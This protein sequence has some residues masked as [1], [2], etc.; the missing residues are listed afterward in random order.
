MFWYDNLRNIINALA[1]ED[2]FYNTNRGIGL[3]DQPKNICLHIRSHVVQFLYRSFKSG[4]K[5]YNPNWWYSKKYRLIIKINAKIEMTNPNKEIL[6]NGLYIFKKL[7]DK[8]SIENIYKK[9]IDKES[10]ALHCFK[11]KKNIN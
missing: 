9:G 2:K 7:L 1:K 6:N 10:S 4:R 5:G 3:L 8:N 11:P